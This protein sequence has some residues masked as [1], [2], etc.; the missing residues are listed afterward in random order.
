LAAEN[1]AGQASQMRGLGDWIDNTGPS[2]VPAAYRTPAASI[3]QSST[4]T[5]TLFG[6]ILTSIYRV[7]G[8]SQDLTLVADTALRALITNFAR[9]DATT[10]AMRT[11][12][13][14][15]GSGLVKLAVSVYQGDHGTISIVDMNPDCAP[16]T[17]NK[18]YGYFLNPE[19]Y[20][21]G[22]LIGMGSSRLPNLG[23]GE[24]GLVDWVG[25]LKVNHPGA[26][27]KISVIA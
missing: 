19:Y 1:G 15:S 26:H 10:G 5:E 11:F 2:D 7:S 23:G 17:T 12:N 27:G 3:H 9:A 25:T 13:N 14:D 8:K 20:S 6:G 18:D 24:R 4:L 21:V 22:E 16:D